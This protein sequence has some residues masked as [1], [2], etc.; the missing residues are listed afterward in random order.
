LNCSECV[1]FL[2]LWPLSMILIFNP[3]IVP[4]VWYFILY[5]FASF[6]DFDIW[7][8]NC[9]ECVVFFV[10]P[11]IRTPKTSL[12]FLNY[13]AFQSFD[14]ENIRWRLFQKCVMHAKLDIYVCTTCRLK[15]RNHHLYGF[16]PCVKCIRKSPLFVGFF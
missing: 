14:F 2:F 10:F 1:V 8:W 15:T 11:F 12:F 16:T 3:G 4:N 13:L 6:Y 9:S 5:F 7:S